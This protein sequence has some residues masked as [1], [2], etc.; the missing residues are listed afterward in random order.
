MLEALYTLI[1]SVAI[2]CLYMILT[3]AGEAL[4]KFKLFFVQKD[5]FFFSK[6]LTC[7]MCFSGWVTIALCFVLE[8]ELLLVLPLV[9]GVM[10]FTRKYLE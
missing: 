10:M 1:N 5:I 6:V 9:V 8:V 3:D 2:T 7:Y 4:G